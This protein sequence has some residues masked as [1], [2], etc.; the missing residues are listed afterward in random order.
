MG[1]P[2]R[3]LTPEAQT[4]LA[5]SLKSAKQY[6]YD[7]INT[8]NGGDAASKAKCRGN[9][10]ILLTDGLESCAYEDKVNKIVDYKAAV[11]GAKDLY[12]L[13]VGTF[14][15]GFGTDAGAN[16]D[17]LNNIAQAG[18]GNKYKAFFATDLGTLTDQINTIFKMIFD[19]VARGNPAISGGISQGNGRFYRG[20]FK[21]DWEGHLSSYPLGKDGSIGAEL[22]DAGKLMNDKKD[23]GELFTWVEDKVFPERVDFKTREKDLYDLVNPLGEDIDGDSKIDKNDSKTVVTLTINPGIDG[24]KYKGVRSGNW[25]LGDIYHSTP[26]VLGPPAFKFPDDKFPKKYSAFKETM[27]ARATTIYVG[28]NDGM[29]HA[30][31]ED[32]I[33]KF[34]ILPRSILG[35]LKELRN[36]DHQFYVDSSPRM[37][38]AYVQGRWRTVILSGERSGGRSYFCV[39]VTD[40][41]DPIILWEK[42]DAAMGYTWSRPEISWAKI[43]GQEKF[44]A[45][46][47]GG[48]SATD[49][50]GNAVYVLDME[51]G[52]ILRKF[53]VGD[54]SNKVPAGATGFDSNSDGRVDGVY[55]GDTSGVLWK[56]KI[57]LEEDVNKWSL[58]KL[59]DPGTKHPVFYPPVVTKNNQK[60]ILVYFGQGDELN[61]F[62]DKIANSFFEIWDKGGTGEL[63]WEKTL[64]NGEKVLASAAFANNIIYFTTFKYTGM[65]DNCGA[66]IGR[67]YG[68]SGTRDGAPGKA[69]AFYL[70]PIT[71]ESLKSPREYFTLGPNGKDPNDNYFP[72]LKGIPSAPIIVMDKSYTYFYFSTS[73]STSGGV[74]KNLPAGQARLKFWREVF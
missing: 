53:T 49:N 55:F 74:G 52:D 9:F 63:S 12:D 21:Q 35:N 48:L 54:A 30:F 38:D 2:S 27:K 40:P 41:A 13:G 56:I 69:G 26:L 14:V 7:Y 59:F 61:I 64:D 3:T 31:D 4:P 43:G 62:E 15:I 72:G 70:D 19:S 45:F 73:S 36:K 58:V 28:A 68:L 22:W 65:V 39:D 67:I 46:V 71:G 24:K 37:S 17:V 29:L 60:K 66:G 51:N 18:S 8:Y 33:E 11:K 16:T 1:P 47:G 32:G 23:R 34:A 20:F 44:V 25:F 5:S 6:F 57:D 50:V 10:I 42:S